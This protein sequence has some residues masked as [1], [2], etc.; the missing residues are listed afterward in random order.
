MLYAPCIHRCFL[1]P[2]ACL[3]CSCLMLRVFH[4]LPTVCAPTAQVKRQRSEA[5]NVK[6]VTWADRPAAAAAAAATGE[7]AAHVSASAT[8][9]A[10]GGGCIGI[11]AASGGCMPQVCLLCPRTR[12][13]HACPKVAMYAPIPTFKLYGLPSSVALLSGR[14]LRDMGDAAAVEGE[15]EARAAGSRQQEKQQHQQEPKQEKR[16]TRRHT[17]HWQDRRVEG[18]RNRRVK[19]SKCR[20]AVESRG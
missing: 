7:P 9:A 8:H 19:R 15:Q 11:P 13:M 4:L 17:P 10:A 14:Y 2:H 16:H 12:G 1:P 6:H 20:G 5:S 3:P 18:S